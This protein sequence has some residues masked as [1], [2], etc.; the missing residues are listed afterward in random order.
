MAGEGGDAAYLR[1]YPSDLHGFSIDGIMIAEM[2]K[3]GTG[4]AGGPHPR[5]R[6]PGARRNEASPAT[7]GGCEEV[8][9]T[10]LARGGGIRRTRP[11]KRRM[12][13]GTRARSR[14]DRARALDR[15]LRSG[16]RL[17]GS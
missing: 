9:V 2:D 3:I 12:P 7:R 15:A 6:P 17:I 10:P 8:D 11:R 16:C 14:F 5:G 1:W 4:Y 13:C